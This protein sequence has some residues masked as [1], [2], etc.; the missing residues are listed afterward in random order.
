MNDQ[1]GGRALYGILPPNKKILLIEN[2]EQLN[3]MLTELLALEGCVVRSEADT[4]DILKLTDIF[5]PDLVILDYLLPGINGGELCSQIKRCPYTKHIPV[6]LYS[7]YDK[8]IQSL[9]N[10]GCD[11][12]I[13]K[14]FDIDYFLNEIKKLIAK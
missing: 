9:G 10:Y 4:S 13:P 7:A 5:K 3:E 8:V 1:S 6:I 11:A 12:F 2:D 14:P